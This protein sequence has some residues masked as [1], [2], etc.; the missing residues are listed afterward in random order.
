MA[1]EV[2]PDLPTPPNV[3]RPIPILICRIGSDCGIRMATIRS[4]NDMFKRARRD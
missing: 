4:R 2:A 1:G 3:I